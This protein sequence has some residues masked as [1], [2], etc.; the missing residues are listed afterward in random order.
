MPNT[1]IQLSKYG[2]QV[3]KHQTK[4]YLGLCSAGRSLLQSLD[5]FNLSGKLG[6][7]TFIIFDLLLPTEAKQIPASVF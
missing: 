5:C 1:E 7:H 2:I 6:C 3:Y 4:N